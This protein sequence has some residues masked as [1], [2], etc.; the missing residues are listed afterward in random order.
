MTPKFKKKE[1]LLFGLNTFKKN[2]KF[3]LGIFIV[4]WVISAISG[5]IVESIYEKA[6]Y[7]GI[8]PQLLVYVLNAIL[9]LGIVKIMLDFA[10]KKTHSW[11]SLYLEYPKTIKYII[12]TILYAAIVVGGLIL[13]IVPGV[14]FAIKYQ[15]YAYFIVD[16]NM[17]AIESLKKSGNITKGSLMNLFLFGLI[18]A[19]LSILG[20]LAFGI[21]LLVVIPVISVSSAYIF[22][23]LQA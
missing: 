8:I 15:F 3:L 13:L 23:K 17:G 5:N 6:S 1:A 21:G 7:V 20:L 16:K 19:A 9:A 14:Y 4:V 12:A 18:S 22:R 10:D 11:R 2:W